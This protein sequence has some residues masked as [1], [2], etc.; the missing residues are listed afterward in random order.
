[1]QRDLPMADATTATAARVLTVRTVSEAALGVKTF[2]L[3]DSEGKPLAAFE[4]GAHV[5]VT[6]PN[7]LA[8]AYSLLNPPAENDRY[9]IGV[10]RS[11][12]SAGG[13]VCMHEDIKAGDAIMVTPP[14]NNFK[15]VEDAAHTFLI[16]GGIGIT[17]ILSMI[18]RLNQIGRPWT[19]HYCARTRAHAA[20]LAQ[21]AALAEASGNRAHFHF[22]QE[23]GGARR[24]MAAATGKGGPDTGTHFYCCGPQPMLKAFEEATQALR[25]RAH[26]EYFEAKEAAAL[27]GGFVVVLQKSGMTL[28]VFPGT[29]ILDTLSDAGVEVA[30]S[31]REGICGACET[32]VLEGTPDHRDALLSDAEKQEGRTMMICCSGA[33]SE[34][35]VLDL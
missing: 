17:P 26:V 2:E 10:H 28:P 25:E 1:M 4:A 11:P 16:A 20:F 3:A 27:D 29:S 5:E 14:R 19:L 22:D 9:V 18:H 7:G 6:L 12:D 24:D 8:R 21:L 35:L 33:K 13:S 23:P 15:L 34:R 31:C 32:R 30:F